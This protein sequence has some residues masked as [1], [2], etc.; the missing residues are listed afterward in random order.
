MICFLHCGVSCRGQGNL[1]VG[2]PLWHHDQAEPCSTND[3]EH[4]SVWQPE[5]RRGVAGWPTA[6]GEQG[7]RRRGNGP[8]RGVTSRPCSPPPPPSSSPP[9]WTRR[10]ATSQPRP[11]SGSAP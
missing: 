7:K 9:A 2:R 10:Y 8:T 3:T 6:T 4:C 11:A 1:V 5:Q